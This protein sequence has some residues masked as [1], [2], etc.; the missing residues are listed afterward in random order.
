MTQGRQ[1]VSTGSDGLVKIWNLRDEECVR[2]LDGHVDKV[3]AGRR[4]DGIC[5]TN[6]RYCTC[7]RSGRWPSHRTSGPLCLE[8]LTVF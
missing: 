5:P 1:L 7:D 2:T 6:A 8:A 3:S 4:R